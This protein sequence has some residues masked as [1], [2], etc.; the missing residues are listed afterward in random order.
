[1]TIELKTKPRSLEKHSDVRRDRE[2]G[3]IPAVVYGYGIKNTNVNVDEVELI[4]TLRENGRNAVL[5]ITL[6]N[7]KTNVVLH[8]YQKHPLYGNLVHIDLLAVNMKEELETAVSIRLVGEPKAKAG[9]LE[10]VLYEVIISA[11]PA[12][13]PETLELDVSKLEIGDTLTV[14]DLTAGKEYT[15][16]AD[17]E[18]AVVNLQAPQ[19]LE[20]PTAGTVDVPEPEAIHGTDEE[21]V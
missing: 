11:T 9:V 21:K 7:K 10:Q 4:K 12:N 5:T 16:L 18:D 19:E 13:V 8:D 2:A 15:I 17:G 20:E 14:A 6:D 3:N 1:M